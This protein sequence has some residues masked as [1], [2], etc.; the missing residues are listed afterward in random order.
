MPSKTK[1]QARLMAAAAHNPD[2]AKRVGI[3]QSVAKDFNSAD[4][5]SKLLSD[6][7]KKKRSHGGRAH[8]AIGG[9][10]AATAPKAL[11]GRTRTAPP[12]RN[13]ALGTADDVIK[14]SERAVQAIRNRAL[15]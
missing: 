14:R 11:P 8:Y 10:A 2:F 5:G 4:T 15:R 13:A 6:A 12:G 1:K 7:M 3:K 9:L